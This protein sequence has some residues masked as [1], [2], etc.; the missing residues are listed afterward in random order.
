MKFRIFLCS[1]LAAASL[2]ASSIAKGEMPGTAFTYQGHLKQNGEPANGPVNLDFDLYAAETG[3]KMIA[4]GTVVPDPV[5]VT[6][7]LFTVTIDFGDDAFNG[8][9]RWVEITVG[10]QTLSPRQKITPTPIALSLPGLWTQQNATSPNLIAGFSGNVV[11]DDAIGV[12]IGG[13]GSSGKVNSASGTYNTISGGEHNLA[14][15]NNGGNP[16]NSRYASIA[17]GSQNRA[18]SWGSTVGGGFNNQALLDGD[19]VTGGFNNIADGGTSF[20]GGGNSNHATGGAAV[21]GGGNGNQSTGYQSAIYGGSNNIA[22]GDDSV[23]GGGSAN[24][25]SGVG[26]VVVGG[27]ANKAVGRNSL[28]AGQQAEALHNGTFVWSDD[29]GTATPS[30]GE[31]QWVSRASGGYWLY[32]NSTET[33]GVTLPP[34]GNAWQSISDRNTKDNFEPVDTVE[35]LKRLSAIPMETWNYRSQ[36]PSIRHIGPMAQDFYAAFGVGEDEKHIT[37]I[38]ADGVALAA[39]Q[40]LHQLVQEKDREIGD[41]KA[42]M[43]VLEALVE[44]LAR[45]DE[46]STQ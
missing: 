10:G 4:A 12:H 21:V 40:G 2:G 27:T 24:T 18:R 38:D 11:N 31:N 26:S 30:T 33:A 45:S 39:I 35:V 42:R 22:S 25:A 41:L 16:D 6:D 15:E 3:G 17:G 8:Q 9:A 29:A 19:T 20:V 37:T 1:V 13:G 44:Q 14:G 5:D 7:G 46:G 23:I 28:A 36:D 43:T 34:G 32:S